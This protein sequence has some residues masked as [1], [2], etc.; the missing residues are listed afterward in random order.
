VNCSNALARLAGCALAILLVVLPAGPAHA[1]AAGQARAVRD[2][3]DLLN[4]YY[5][6][7]FGTGFYTSGDR[8]VTVVQ[9]PF[10]LG[11]R[12]VAD[13]GY[14]LRLKL[15]VALGVYDY[16]FDDVLSGDLPGSLSTLS[17]LPGLEWE[18]P[19]HRR[20]TVKP[21]FSAGVGKELGGQE[22]ALLYDFGLK[23]RFRLG[24]DK[25]VEFALVTSLTA[26][27]YRPRGG[28]TQPFGVLAVGLD[29]VI[30]T[31]RTLFGREAFV[32]LTPSYSYYFNKVAFA[33]FDD[34]DNRLREQF[35]FAVSLMSRRPWTLKYF[36]IDRVGLAFRSSG[37]VFGVSLFTSLP[38]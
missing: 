6:A 20:W 27:G 35:E 32:G 4:W 22:S 9:L 37:E 34:A 23:S 2:P 11:L 7:T 17:F 15:P 3:Q 26:A 8:T 30:P 13:D 33:E 29:L 16:D 19:L 25:G 28:P 10:A 36:D 1:Q 5:A 31:Q 14:G 24:E 21:Y 18:L 12:T 38:F